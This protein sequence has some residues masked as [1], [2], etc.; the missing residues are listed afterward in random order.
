MTPAGARRILPRAEHDAMGQAVANAAR[1]DPALYRMLLARLI[2][3]NQADMANLRRAAAV[4]DWAGVQRTV[5]R[6]KGSA[7]LVRCPTLVAAGKSLEAAARQGKGAVVGALLPRY[8]A[9][10]TE[11]NDALL[12]LHAATD[13]SPDAAGPH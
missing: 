7:A 4:R 6:I 9:I 10:V 13:A 1:D 5:H 8:I 2:E 12:A 11:F 3:T